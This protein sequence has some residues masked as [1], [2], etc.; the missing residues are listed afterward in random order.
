MCVYCTSV[1]S[2]CECGDLAGVK[3]FLVLCSCQ[4]HGHTLPRKPDAI[5]YI[6]VAN[7]NA[8]GV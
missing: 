6:G 1:G 3:L 7:R 4:I 5:L 2:V 8:T